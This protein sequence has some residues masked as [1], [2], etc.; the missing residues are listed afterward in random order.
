M[1]TTP[2][3]TTT[4][5]PANGL[6]PFAMPFTGEAWAKAMHDGFERSKAFW[7]EYAKLESQGLA[8]ARTVM[9]EQGKLGVEAMNYVAGLGQ[10][11]RKLAFESTKRTMDMLAGR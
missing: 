4:A 8:H 1:S 2:E 6:F 7:D 5:K 10:E 3:T 9:G 11:W